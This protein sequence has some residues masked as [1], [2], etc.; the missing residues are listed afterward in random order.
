MAA[1]LDSVTSPARP[2][3][4][5]AV[6]A[7]GDRLTLRAKLGFGIGDFA[8][9]LYWQ[10]TTLYLLYYYTDV[11][12]LSAATA[13]WIFG[14]AMLWDALCDPVAG[15]LANRTRTRWG[16]Y[17]PYLLFGCIPLALSFIA[18]FYPSAATGDRLLALVLGTHMLFRT[19]YTVLSMP[20]N[21]L[22]ATLTRSSQERGGLA[23]ARMVCASSAGLLVALL[24]L[25]LVHGFGAGDEKQG[26]LAVMTL[27]AV[28]SLPVFL[29]T[30]LS[31]EERVQADAHTLSVRDALAVV[32][33]NRAFLLVCGMSVALMAAGT[34]LS[35]TLPYVL[36]YAL[37]REDL[38][39]T[40][41]GVV[42]LQVF[43]AVPLWA[44]LMRRTSKR[45]VALAGGGLAI[46]AYAVLGALG[47]PG[48]PA[49]LLLLGVI[50]F[51][52]AATLLAS[53][54]MIPDTV[55][56]GE[57]RT[58]IRGEG[59]IFG[60]IAFAQKGALAIAVGGVGHLLG[61]LGFAANQA[62]APA[63][64]DGIWAMLWQGP[65]AL[66]VVGMVF[67]Y[68]YPVTPGMHRDLLHE[69]GR[70]RAAAGAAP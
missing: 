57:W 52:S 28:V 18:M 11:V 44:W 60:V 29:L 35:K 67:A 47:T 25:K 4:P 64:L 38:I 7:G 45:L 62:Q 8:F 10:A 37:H 68:F 9:N 22:M 41:L 56:Y 55:E 49:L 5:A 46:G 6:P 20:Y 66:L 16:R 31:T 58:G 3:A 61:A 48:V 15:F 51:A 36:K 40:A 69:L 42:A 50:G 23:A 2:E 19:A 53:W 32:L 39:G 27:Y 12:G 13:G 24:T 21:S 30:F 63:T 59:T 14:A 17:R 65:M 54:A 26:F 34:F 70:R 43:I 1:N 33:R